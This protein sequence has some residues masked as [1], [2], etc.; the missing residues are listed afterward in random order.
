ML[1]G[2]SGDCLIVVN[3]SG[4][5][6]KV[7]PKSFFL[8]IKDKTIKETVIPIKKETLRSWK[9]PEFSVV[10]EGVGSEH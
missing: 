3:R 8:W 1:S 6:G 5:P 7:S 4:C 9:H 10:L 2:I